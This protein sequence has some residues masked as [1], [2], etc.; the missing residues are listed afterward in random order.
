MQPTREEQRQWL[1]NVLRETGKTPTVLA[2]EAGLA[3]TTLTRFLNSE[4]AKNVLSFRTVG[5]VARAAGVAP[6][7][8]VVAKPKPQGQQGFSEDA[9]PFD[10]GP[11]S[12]WPRHVKAAVGA[13]LEGRAAAD[14]WE[15]KSDA[16]EQAGYRHGDIVIVDL[17]RAP[18]KGDIVCAQIYQWAA[19]GA[20]TLF[21]IYEPP[22]LIAAS[23]APELRRPLMVDNDQIV[24]K[25]VVTDV[26]RFKK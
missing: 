4:N 1:L 17:A 23:A 3:S 24:V 26:L 16:L 20:E 22:Y 18:E 10:Y 14:P 5:A 6:P 9:A 13:L 2:R 19:G 8:F 15:L 11:A 7:G 25:G 21:R 12:G